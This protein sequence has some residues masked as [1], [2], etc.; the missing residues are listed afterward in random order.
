MAQ[1]VEPS[2]ED[3]DAIGEHQRHPVRQ[4]PLAELIREVA[5]FSAETA[6]RTGRAEHRRDVRMLDRQMHF[7]VTLLL[8]G[9]DAAHV[10]HR[11]RFFFRHRRTIGRVLVRAPSVDAR[12]RRRRLLE[13]RQLR[14]GRCH[15][16]SYAAF[17]R[18]T[19]LMQLSSLLVK[20][21]YAS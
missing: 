10:L 15:E 13:W 8:H 20:M 18:S 1:I 14:S 16:S 5:K 2:F 21:R 4:P 17:G 11:R 19:G 7:E 9:H 3:V 6:W 12:P